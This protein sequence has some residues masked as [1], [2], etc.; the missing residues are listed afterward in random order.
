ML[1]TLTLFMH[2]CCQLGPATTLVEAAWAHVN[3]SIRP[4]M[5]GA[6]EEDGEALGPAGRKRVLMQK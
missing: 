6:A 2:S 1:V 3:V 4:M 5:V